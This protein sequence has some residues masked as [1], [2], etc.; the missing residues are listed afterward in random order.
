V[1]HSMTNKRNKKRDLT[2]LCLSII[3]LIMVNFVGSFVFHRFD[4]T[5]EKRYTLSDDTKKLLENLD[6]VVYVQVYLEGDFP[7]GFKRLRNETKEML[8]EF[9]AYSNNNVE[10]EFINPSDNPNK[11]QQEEVYKQLYKKGLQ[12][13][14]LEDKTDQGTTERLIWPGAIVSYKGHQLPWQLLKIELGA[15]S[16]GQLNNSVQALE[17]GFLAC[18]RNLSTSI[19]PVIGII[20]GHGELDT[21]SMEDISYSLADFYDVKRI[22]IDSQ[23]DALKGVSAIIVAKPVTAFSKKDKFII[24]QFIMKGGKALWLIDPLYTSPDS[25]RKNGGTLAVPYDLNLDDMLFKYGVRVN[26]DMIMDVQSSA[27]PVKTGMQGNEPKIELKPWIFSPLFMPSANHKIVKNLD[28]I[29]GDFCASI[30]TI[31]VPNV[32]KT[33][34]L[35]SSKYSRN[36]VAPVRV[37]MRI[38]NMEL[39][40]TQFNVPYRNVAVLLE[41][42]FESVYKNRIT[43]QIAKDSAIGYK[44][45]SVKTKMIVISDGDMIRNS[46]QY[47]SMK[48]Y[49][50]GYDKYT[51]HTFGNKK[52]ILNCMNYLCDDEGLIA[53]RSRELTL[54]LLDKKKLKNEKLKWQLTNT[55]LPLLLILVYGIIHTMR[56]KRKYSI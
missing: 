55:I 17:Y 13:F 9:R 29:K 48:A 28:M 33:I 19:R 2:A 3:I 4:L 30:D 52:F 27:I 46:I 51:N 14:N 41:G 39:D 20:D 32:K 23:L 6:D 35:Q 34:L 15:S 5:S 25:L 11:E 47:S 1:V 53:V 43:P 37:D 36:I 18:I 21:L 49:P 50:L 22:A 38:L 8:D 10:Y 12:R 40:E 56:R 31:A 44:D 26:P 42:E 7:A 24:D 54:R 16:E 45:H